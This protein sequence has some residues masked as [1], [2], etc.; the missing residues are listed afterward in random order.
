MLFCI[1]NRGLQLRDICG[2][3]IAHLIPVLGLHVPD[4][5]APVLHPHQHE[6]ADPDELLQHGL[7]EGSRIQHLTRKHG[8]REATAVSVMRG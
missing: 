7:A 1:F 5:G 6:G 3:A 8:S 2:T 4:R